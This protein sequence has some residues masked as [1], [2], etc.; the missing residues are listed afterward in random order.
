MK[1]GSIVEC[2]KGAEGIL[3]KGCLYTVKDVTK[4]GNI[5]LYEVEP[6]FPFNCF[7]RDRFKEIQDPDTGM[8][9]LDE[10]NE[11]QLIH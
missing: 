10:I 11:L 1:V 2:V 5:L 3:E 7:N 4:N 9:I 8:E 6:P